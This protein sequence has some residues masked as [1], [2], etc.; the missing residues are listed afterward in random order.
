LTNHY[1]VFYSKRPAIIRFFEGLRLATKKRVFFPHA[2]HSSF[3]ILLFPLL[4]EVEK[5]VQ[6]LVPIVSSKMKGRKGMHSMARWMK[7]LGQMTT[8]LF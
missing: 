5:L 8:I 3:L 6:K 1:G 7:P 2:C 4:G